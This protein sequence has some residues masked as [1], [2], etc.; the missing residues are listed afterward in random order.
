M[1]DKR[2]SVPNQVCKQPPAGG[3][4]A[5]S[6]RRRCAAGFT[7]I[8]LL[9]V[10]AIIAILAALL[11]PALARSKQQA[12]GVKCLSNNK[13]MT[14]AWKMY[15]GD[16]GG[17]LVNNLGGD[18]MDNNNEPTWVSDWMD[19][20]P[21]W[22]DNTN[23]TRLLDPRDSLLAPYTV[24]A[25]I[26]KCPADPSMALE[27]GTSYP[28]V[29]SMSMN[30]AVGR[31]G[32]GYWLNYSQPSVNFMVFQKESDYSRMSTAMLW[33]FV[34]EHPDSI[35]DGCC[36]QEIA[37]TLESTAWVDV[38]ASYHNGACGF[39]FAD[40]HA[41][42]HKWKDSRTD[43]PIYN[44]DYLYNGGHGQSQPPHWQANNQDVMWIGPRTSIAQ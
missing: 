30:A 41:E 4:F 16:N 39:G 8:E 6:P 32:N 22:A 27:G 36:A 23:I 20:T 12:Q 29:R 13:Q 34:D 43:F 33:V 9:V 40:G 5:R 18:L 28:R 26:Y 15:S 25:A 3:G 42:V 11:L 24:S 14:T 31:F 44:D 2:Q 38:P 1:I 17:W 7:L 10:I 37:P 19:F 35:N 21:N